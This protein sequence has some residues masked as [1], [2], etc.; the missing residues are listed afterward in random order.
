[1]KSLDKLLQF[2]TVQN[3]LFFGLLIFATIIFIWLIQD[4]IAP[5]FW[6][7]VLAIVFNPL[8]KKLLR[9]VGNR[10]N[11]ASL[12]T[13]I[14]IIFIVVIP[15]YATGTL[16]VKESFNFYQTLS[17]SQE[18]IVGNITE[19]AE[20]FGNANVDAEAIE[21]RATSF[22]QTV[23]TWLSEQALSIGQGTFSI[24]VKLLLMIYIL[25][26]IFRDGKRIAN[27]L[28]G[29]LPLG[30]E[31]EKKLYDR[32][33]SITRAI[34]K[35]TLV[36]A[37][38]QGAIG[39]ILFWIAGI[40]GAVLWAVVMGFLSVIP[41]VGPAI[42]WLPAGLFLLL[43]GAIWQG[44]LVLVVGALFISLIDNILRPT[45][46]GRDTRMP[47]AIIL[48]STLGG[49][50]LFGITGFIVGPIIAGFFLSMWQMFESDY[51]SEL[52]LH[53]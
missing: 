25:F 9:S 26:F 42:I 37:I 50:S 22:V 44:I 36:I 32:F 11:I 5:I 29:A 24:V 38:I 18:N 12:I 3:A 31:R 46:V 45:L 27:T 2:K 21:A 8:Y 33:C 34:F 14:A 41:A 19:V 53:G 51:Q 52:E 15:V 7:V 10:K 17:E 6:A 48:L 39:G 30:D 40:D 4:F 35:G 20:L 16:V 49:L 13:I 23:V 28:M 47:D 1:M 43:T